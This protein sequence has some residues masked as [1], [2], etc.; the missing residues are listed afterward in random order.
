MFLIQFYIFVS[1][2][3]QYCQITASSK[4]VKIKVQM[5]VNLK[6]PFTFKWDKHLKQHSIYTSPFTIIIII[7]TPVYQIIYYGNYFL[8][9]KLRKTTQKRD[10]VN[11]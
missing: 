8:S 2:F 3:N 1:F 10:I 6:L 9:E 4:K 7:F 5:K 11:L